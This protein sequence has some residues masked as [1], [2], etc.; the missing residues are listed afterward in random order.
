M[1]QKVLNNQPGV[2]KALITPRRILYASV[3][4]I[5]GLL[6]LGQ[7][8]L[9]SPPSSKKAKPPFRPSGLKFAES[10][11]RL[12]LA[13]EP[14][15]GQ[16]DSQV[17]YLSHG[18]GYT[19]FLTASEAVLVLQKPRANP[20]SKHGKFKNGKKGGKFAA[21]S[22]PV[23]HTSPVALHMKLEGAQSGTTYQNL[24]PLPGISNYLIGNDRSKWHTRIPQYAKV[25]A[26]EV[27]PG[28]DMVYYGH[29][30]R[31]EYDFVVKP[32][33][34]PNAIH[35]K[36][37]GAQ[38]ATVN[39]QGD[40][41]LGIEGGK[42]AFRSP[43]VYQENEGQRNPVEGH[44]R[45]E[46][47]GGIRFEV[48][49]YDKTKPLIIDPTLDYSTDFGG[50]AVAVDGNGD[51]YVTGQTTNND[52]P[53]TSGVFQSVYPGVNVTVT[54]FVFELN[55]AGSALIYCTYLGGNGGSSGNGDSGNA[56][57]VD[58]N[59]DAYVTGTTTSTNF[60][61][62]PGALLTSLPNPNQSAF[63]TELNPTG[64]GLVYSTYLG[65]NGGSSIWGDSGFSIAVDGSGNAYVTGYTQSS[66]FP[67]S[68]GAYQATLNGDQNVFV[69]EL[70][71]SAIG[72]AQLAY[73]TFLGGNSLDQGNGIALDGKGNIYVTGSTQSTNFPTTPGAFQSVYPMGVNIYDH[74]FVTEL[75]PTQPGLVYSTFLGGENTS[76]STG[77]GV[78]DVCNAIAVDGMGDA[79]VTGYTDS[80]DFP[81]TSGALQT[82][83]PNTDSSAFVTE[84]N[85]TGTGLVYSTYLGGS[86]WEE[87]Y[88]IAV[89]GS[90]DA[91]LTG[92]TWSPD[93]P[94]TPDAIQT[95][96]PYIADIPFLTEL[97][98]AGNG[99]IYSTY[100]GGQSLYD[101]SWGTSI[102][103][104]GHGG[105]Y[106][107]GY[108][109]S[110]D[111]PTTAGAYQPANGDSN[112][113]AKFQQSN[114]NTP[115]VT[116]T[117]SSMLSPTATVSST[118]SSTPTSS[119][120][121]LPS[122]TATYTPI[123]TWTATGTPTATATSSPTHSNTPT[124]TSTWTSTFPSTPTPTITLTPLYSYT[125]TSSR[126]I[127]LTPTHTL[128]PTSTFTATH[129][130]TPTVTSTPTNTKTAT[131]T[132]T[133]TLSPT[134]TPT[135][136]VTPT[137]TS[138]ASS[139]PTFTPPFTGTPTGTPSWTSTPPFS[140]TP[141]ATST[142]T[143]TPTWTPTSSATPMPTFTST[144]TPT[145]TPSPAFTSTPTPTPTLPVTPELYPNPAGGGAVN[146][147][148]AYGGD[149]QVDVYTLAFRRVIH[150]AYSQ[151][152]PGS[153][154]SLGLK[155]ERG[156]MLGDGLY[157]VVVK[158]RGNRWVGK[159][160]ILR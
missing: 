102:A 1:N 69:T 160:L 103:L 138:T 48:K 116:P 131:S 16:A 81:T 8:G 60:P 155:D 127:T 23:S 39:A 118:P 146:L 130:A 100:F 154:L 80:T 76:T 12:P 133:S 137:P 156:N 15:Q 30:G 19:L 134:W 84:L 126:T 89:D 53:T 3:F 91:Y 20:H 28:V 74:S 21:S 85:L 79:Y 4:F 96:H 67:T 32:G 71:P 90:G 125:P 107:A 92:T 140:F 64:T 106:L 44:Y 6:L 159:L 145:W 123:S 37:E 157:Y 72:S 38:S 22:A 40:L 139:T 88:A 112:F 26:H 117:Q 2:S 153:S 33:A 62:S 128:S 150:Q 101:V 148:D 56:I 43:A 105:I 144:S 55:P 27:Y 66:N 124:V 42:V 110:S 54:A 59:G 57:A 9:V 7:M 25:Q 141:T 93:F 122:N 151:Q 83:I 147:F 13:F 50:D 34:D 18:N 47:D 129:S 152:L 78:S 108:T 17:Q 86:D 94:L 51:A 119:P 121:F 95:S 52:F 14:N 65:G 143:S 114:F 115:S 142:W 45:M 104:D 41:E 24:E 29:Q 77:G 58:G 46:Q 11:G 98:P 35:L 5:T 120:T 132:F 135:A 158:A 63:V 61:T 49:D 82:T 31:L 10:Y 36:Y 109:D 111:F 75:N 70:N 97:N 113:M 87:G 73:S 136:T 68:P 99:L 149:L